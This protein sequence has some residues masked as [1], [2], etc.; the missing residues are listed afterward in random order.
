MSEKSKVSA[1]SAG[2][3][4]TLC[5]DFILRKNEK[6]RVNM[7]VKN[8]WKW[9]HTIRCLLMLWFSQNVKAVKWGEES[10]AWGV[11]IQS[12]LQ[13]LSD[14]FFSS[15]FHLSKQKAQGP[16]KRLFIYLLT[17]ADN[18]AVPRSDHPHCWANLSMLSWDLLATFSI[19]SQ[20]LVS[21]CGEGLAEQ[22]C[23]F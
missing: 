13:S 21:R 14:Y 1:L 15:L 9:E 4:L 19:R 22:V 8:P 12:G 7:L 2:R 20:N 3:V 5:S 10:G 18:S 17:P 11:S 23:L 6:P 16:V